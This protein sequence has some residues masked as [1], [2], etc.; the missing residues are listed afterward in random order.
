MLSVSADRYKTLSMAKAGR[1][2]K[3]KAEQQNGGSAASVISDRDRL[4]A[5]QSLVGIL[6]SILGGLD[7]LICKHLESG[8]L[9]T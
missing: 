2:S 4:G 5:V 1:K 9:S 3:Q 8:A 6:Q 7:E